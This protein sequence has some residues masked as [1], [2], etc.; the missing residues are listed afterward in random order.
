MGHHGVRFVVR[1]ES[2]S[3]VF[4]K[5]I[6]GGK[7]VEESRRGEDNGKGVTGSEKS[8]DPRGRRTSETMKSHGWKRHETRP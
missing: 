7:A 8:A 4:L 6:V 5:E 1:G 2:D 3:G